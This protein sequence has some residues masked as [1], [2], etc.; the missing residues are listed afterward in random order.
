MMMPL[1]AQGEDEVVLTLRP[2]QRQLFLDDELIDILQGLRRTLHQPVKYAGSPVLV[3]EHPWEDSSLFLYGSVIREADGFK[4]WYDGAARNGYRNVCFATSLDGLRWEKRLDLGTVPYMEHERTNIVLVPNVPWEEEGVRGSGWPMVFNVIAEPPAE[5]P[6]QK[7]RMLFDDVAAYPLAGV[8]KPH[9]ACLATS[10]DGLNWTRYPGN[11]LFNRW[12]MGLLWDPDR[13]IYVVF[14]QDPGVRRVRRWESPDLIHWGKHAVVL[15]PDADDPP[16]TEF[17][18]IAPALIDGLYVGLLHVHHTDLE[19]PVTRHGGTM[20]LQLVCSRDGIRW[21]RVSR[22]PF[23]ANGA[24]GEFDHGIHWGTQGPVRVGDEYFFYLSGV[25]G[26][27]LSAGRQA[28]IGVARLRLDGFVSLGPERGRGT[29]LTKPFL[30]EGR[31]LRLNV[32]PGHGRVRV[33][34]HHKIFLRE[35]QTLP[36]YS[37]EECDPITCDGVSVPVT[38]NGQGDLRA[39]AGRPI[40]LLIEFEGAASMCSSLPE[41]RKANSSQWPVSWKRTRGEPDLCH[42]DPASGDRSCGGGDSQSPGGQ[43]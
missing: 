17:H 24:T 21:R 8:G 5:D 41:R 4:M 28:S 38:W 35:D 9:G 34:I 26:D 14:S 11:P 20:D 13:Q 40:R 22:E 3:P 32:D 33:A 10:P 25:D 12:P 39:L 18:G 37:L 1:R 31:E 19:E 7:Y 23:V 29:L 42:P 30:F 43:P 36:G 15:V 16:G 2:E 27:M 6:E